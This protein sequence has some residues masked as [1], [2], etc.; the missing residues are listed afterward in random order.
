MK[1]KDIKKDKLH[2]GDLVRRPYGKEFGLGVVVE[3]K[4]TIAE[5]YWFEL[6]TT[7]NLPISI[8]EVLSPQMS[9]KKPSYLTTSH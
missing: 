2:P 3:V 9:Y 5:I 8:I 1:N 7:F 4:D 6:G